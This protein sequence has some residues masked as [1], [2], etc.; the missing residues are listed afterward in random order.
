[1]GVVLAFTLWFVVQLFLVT[2][3]KDKK[4]VYVPSFNKD[5]ALMRDLDLISGKMLID[6]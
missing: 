4:A 6:L 3:S 5:I 2:F 1:M